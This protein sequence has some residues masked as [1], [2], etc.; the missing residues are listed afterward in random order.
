MNDD[1][2]GL[3]KRLLDLSSKN[4][5]QQTLQ[6]LKPLFE[7][8]NNIADKDFLNNLGVISSR[9]GQERMASEFFSRAVSIS[10]NF[11]EAHFNLGFLFQKQGKYDDAICSF[12]QAIVARPNYADAFI[13]ISDALKQQ[14]KVSVA[15]LH[16]R[17]ALFAD[18]KNIRAKNNLAILLQETGDSAQAVVLLEELASENKTAVILNNL[19]AAY[20]TESIPDK[21][22]KCVTEAVSLDPANPAIVKNYVKTLIRYGK[23]VSQSNLVDLL[24]PLINDNDTEAAELAVSVFLVS[25]KFVDGLELLERLDFHADTLHFLK[26]S[27]YRSLGEIEAAQDCYSKIDIVAPTKKSSKFLTELVFTSDLTCAPLAEVCDLRRKIAGI[28]FSSN[29]N[30]G[31]PYGFAS[32]KQNKKIRVGYVSGDF[33]T[34]SASKVFGCLL[35]HFNK[36]KFEVVCYSTTND[37]LSDPY[38]QAFKQNASFW[39]NISKFDDDAACNLIRQDQIDVLVDLGS[40]S[41]GGRLGIFAKKA[42]RVQATGWGYVGGT[43]I[44]AVDYFFAD[45]HTVTEHE[46]SFFSEEVF[47]LPSIVSFQYIEDIPPLAPAPFAVNSYITFGSFNRLAK[48]TDHTLRLW[49]LVFDKFNSC[50]LIIKTHELNDAKVVNWLRSRLLK[51]GLDIG[52]IQLIGRSNWYDHLTVIGQVDICLDSFPHSGGV[53]T[54]ESILMGVPVMALKYDS[55]MGRL[56]ASINANLGLH[57]WIADDIDEYLSKLERNIE[58]ID[59]FGDFRFS[60]RKNLLSSFICDGKLYT[61]VVENAYSTMVSKEAPSV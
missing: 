54:L 23:N 27:L 47:Y 34:H 53:T 32:R 51:H 58:R 44:E 25:A 49:K 24:R 50:Q 20:L 6:L 38:T 21:A 35:T 48:I 45:T 41:S 19:S 29:L 18:P 57:E 60:L 28:L 52:R 59:K 9:I 36:D 15:I 33:R 40:Y 8:R 43:G 31:V 37:N 22:I 30:G 61:S 13:Q 12:E 7:K 16:L 42:A 17:K 4:N 11:A 5:T 14:G 46:K 1:E 2:I 56:S 3:I 10:P 26:A 55:I 39:R